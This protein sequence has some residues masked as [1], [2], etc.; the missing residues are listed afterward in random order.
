MKTCTSCK[1]A[2]AF[3][4]FQKNTGRKD[5]LQCHCKACFKERYRKYD[6]LANRKKH[7][8]RYYGLDWEV[9]EQMYEDQNGCCH[10]CK[11]D[12]LLYEKDKLNVAHVDHDHD[13]GEVR[14][15]LCHYCNAGI[16]YLQDNPMLLR[17]AADYLEYFKNHPKGK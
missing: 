11:K 6:P 8:K 16:G 15:L 13:T 3:S 4:E 12:M 2:K 14:G 9:Y 17:K 7:V 1:Q 5:G 10:I